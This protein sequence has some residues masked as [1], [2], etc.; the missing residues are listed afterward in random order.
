MNKN[1]RQTTMGGYHN[2]GG[3]MK[4]D[5]SVGIIIVVHRSENP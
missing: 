5:D 2:A 4:D 3:P 1:K